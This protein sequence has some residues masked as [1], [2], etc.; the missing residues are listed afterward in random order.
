LA[1]NYKRIYKNARGTIKIESEPDYGTV[2]II[3]IPVSDVTGEPL[4]DNAPL[5]ELSYPVLK[6]GNDA[7]V[8]KEANNFIS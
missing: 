8:I 3:D 5:G 1:F 4:V 2:F 7:A 6:N